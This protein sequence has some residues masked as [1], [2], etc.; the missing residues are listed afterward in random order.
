MYA[1]ILSQILFRD[2]KYFIPTPSIPSYSEHEHNISLQSHLEH[3]L[4]SPPVMLNHPFIEGK[5]HALVLSL[6]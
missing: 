3:L 1:F 2:R 5:K 4:P 6:S